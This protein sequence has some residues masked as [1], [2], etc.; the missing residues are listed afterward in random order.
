M[1]PVV[2][3]RANAATNEVSPSSPRIMCTRIDRLGNMTSRC[4]PVL[5]AIARSQRH[6]KLSTPKMGCLGAERAGRT[7]ARW[8]T[9][10]PDRRIVLA[11]RS[12]P[13][14]VRGRGAHPCKGSP[15]NGLATPMTM[16]LLHR[17]GRRGA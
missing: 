12:P 13:N 8:F 5:D 6:S 10:R 2:P 7:N 16:F 17:V 3:I 9:K 14:L 15:E 4:G 11:T 1:G